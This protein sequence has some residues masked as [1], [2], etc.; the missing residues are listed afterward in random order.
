MIDAAERYPERLIPFM[1]ID[2]RKASCLELIEHFARHRLVKGYGE[3]VDTLVFDDPLRMRIYGKCGELGLPIIFFGAGPHSY[4][5]VGLPR[6]E[7]CL[8]EF[9]DTIFI[10]HGPRWWEAIS[11]ADDGSC[12]YPKTPVVPGG[13]ADRFL[14]QYPNMYA[15]ISAG[16]GYNAMTRDPEF[17]QGFLRRNWGKLL[18][19]TDYLAPVTRW[20]MSNGCAKPPWMKRTARPSPKGMHEG[21]YGWIDASSGCPARVTVTSTCSSPAST[22]T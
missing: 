1:H 9:P 4:D 3:F 17:T 11:A 22:C 19:A 21:F 12:S 10:G 7:K 15:D 5:E 6:L 16:S 2:P 14:Q 13:A 8:R 20:A 18:F